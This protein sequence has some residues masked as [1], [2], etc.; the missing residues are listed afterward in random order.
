[1]EIYGADI[2]G[3]EG[4]LIRFEATLEQTRQG[5]SLLGLASKVVK[6]G[7]IRAVK[8]IETLGD[9][10]AKIV[11][12][13]GYIVQLSP[14]ETPKLS[15]GLDLPIAVMLL[16]A[17]ILQ[18]LDSLSHKIAQIEER[19][20]RD[21]LN[22]KKREQLLTQLSA[23][24]S[25]R[26]K[27]QQYRKRL[28]DN[29]CK[30]LLIATLDITTGQLRS[31]QYGM[32]GMM[33]AAKPGFTL[34]VP[35]EAEQHAAIVQQQSAK[36]VVAKA[37]NLKEVWEIL[38]GLAPLRRVHLTRKHIR[39]PKEFE[40]HVPD[41]RDIEGVARA[42]RAMAIALA[43][44]HNIL[45]VGPPGQGK[46]MLATAATRLLPRLD[47]EEIFQLNKIYSAK[48]QLGENEIVLER[49]FCNVQSAVTPAA[50]FGGGAQ[51]PLPGLFSL[52]HHGVL[53]FDE[54]NLFNPQLI[55]HLRN[56]LN[57]RIQRVQR[58]RGTLEYP[59]RFILAA[60]MNPCKCGWLSHHVCPKCGQTFF[61]DTDRCAR[62]PQEHPVKKC[63]CNKHDIEQY[64]AK[65]SVP[66]LDR[67]DLKVLVSPYDKSQDDEMRYASVTIKHRIKEA[68]R[69]QRE[70][71]RDA[72]NW[73]CNG[74]VPNKAE[75]I[76]FTSPL[77]E[78]VQRSL[79][80][81]CR[82][83]DLTK[84]M[85]VKLYLVARTIADFEESRDI[86]ITDVKEAIELMGLNQDYFRHFVR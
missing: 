23:L 44:G 59:C 79:E 66:L 16:H 69:V 27:I 33:A 12:D 76:K 10:W 71:Y 54:V 48:G 78:N 58:V 26:K 43:G 40:R 62:H 29:S 49:P 31:P 8:A 3:I 24:I 32:F 9:E 39:Q 82:I 46:S 36:T 15:S 57:D 64:H 37:A 7:Y 19:A 47:N 25:E 2:T 1:M 51:R 65:L 72:R 73:S 52:A 83:L 14:A 21:G 63:R 11:T 61:H 35:E 22:S 75:F 85:E 6:E 81:Y 74:D 50:L 70:R 86:R 84:R 45:L 28:A 34:I 42:K 53:F 80:E 68:R 4:Q 30:Y 38:L 67:I 41:L 56:T 55:E 77:R 17:G 5:V 13:K 60:A 20:Q 18:D